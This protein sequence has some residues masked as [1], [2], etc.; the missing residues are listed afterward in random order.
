MFIQ[1]FVIVLA[2]LNGAAQNPIANTSFEAIDAQGRVEGWTSDDIAGARWVRSSHF[3]KSGKYSM[4]LPGSDTT[5]ETW[6]RLYSQPVA[7]NEGDCIDYKAWVRSSGT[8]R[9]YLQA[10]VEF[11]RHTGPW[12]PIEP[13]AVRPESGRW[14]GS[15]WTPL[16]FAVFAPRGATEI[17]LVVRG[18]IQSEVR[19]S[20]YVDEVDCRIISFKDYLENRVGTGREKDIL[21]LGADTMAQ[22]S[23]GCYGNER[24]ATPHLDALAAEGRVYEKVTATAP[25]T[26]PSHAS[27]MTSLYPSQHT[28]EDIYYALPQE[29]ETLAEMLKKKGYFTAAFVWSAYDGYLG[30]IMQYD[31]GF[32]F[33][34][35]CADEELVTQSLY[36]FMDT[37]ADNLANMNEGGIFI[38]YHLW[39]P[40]SP[41][42]NRHPEMIVNKGLLGTAPTIT[43]PMIWRIYQ[44]EPGYFNTQDIDYMRNVYDW[45]S[46]QVDANIGGLMARMNWCGLA[47]DLNV[48]LYADHGEAFSEKPGVWGHSN[49]YESCL[50]TPLIL[51]FPGIIAPGGR[52]TDALASNLDILPTIMALTGSPPK[53]S[54]EGRNL[55]DPHADGDTARF[56]ISESRRHGCL[57]IRGNRYKL[58]V[59]NASADPSES[60]NNRDHVWTLYNPKTPALYELYD[61]REDPA[62]LNDIAEVQPQILARMKQ[63]LDAHCARTGINP[64]GGGGTGIRPVEGQISQETLEQ[65]GAI[66]YNTTPATVNITPETTKE[67]KQLDKKPTGIGNLDWLR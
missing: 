7:I 13:R 3:S 5:E 66:G 58:V 30:P 56:G 32:D 43:W 20:W 33:Y 36:K 47:D 37:N 46:A 53:A 57:S 52:E 64:A 31:Q 1:G 9:Q 11:R 54:W 15:E 21:L 49:P 17:R 45:E 18:S 29:V 51:R 28:L 34:F 48:V 16:G 10:Y 25:W 2:A 38:W 4:T 26:K 67:S 14:L 42:R 59:R 6:I 61:L 55:L 50:R 62:E 12:L 40:H 23:L 44:N 27:V 35:H 41:Y 65:L 24:A 60:Q 8:S 19:I 63:A 39:E 22:R